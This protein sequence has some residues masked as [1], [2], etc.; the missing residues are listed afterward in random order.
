MSNKT[1]HMK[2]FIP[3]LLL[4][5]LLFSGCGQLNSGEPEPVPTTAN[6]VSED[7][8]APTTI[9]AAQPTEPP[10]PT[11]TPPPPT[12]VPTPTPPLAA[13]VNGRTILLQ[14]YQTELQRY[15]Q[16]QLALGQ[17]PVEGY[18]ERVFMALVEQTIIRESAA[19]NGISISQEMI[20]ARVNEM[21]DVAGGQENFEAWLSANQMTA[22][23]FPEVIAYEM[24]TDEVEL[25]VTADVPYAVPQVRAS[26]LEV[27]DAALAQ[28][29]L[30]QIQNGAD[31]AALA[32]AYSLDQTTA[33]NGGD[34]GFFDSLLVP[35]LEA[36]AFSLEIGAVS[37]VI[38]VQHSNGQTSHYIITVTERDEGRPLT[39]EQR[40][41]LL[42][43]K[44]ES[45]LF[46]QL[47]QAEIVR[48]E[49]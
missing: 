38:T 5:G 31:F 35:E 37:D 15:E 8:V 22:E 41:V 32:Q 21:I 20:D 26:Y 18:T 39:D 14:D 43:E 1:R 25:F 33:P 28:S 4:C 42:K 9:E 23:E 40:S 48:F 16:G 7:A 6:L 3:F 46:E 19:A 11:P 17:S 44:F 13:L 49:N 36:A 2:K 29:I 10:L 30:D 47:S 24:L 27:A 45:W 12:P 34:L